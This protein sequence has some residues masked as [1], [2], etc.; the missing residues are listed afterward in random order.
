M[1]VVVVMVK[2]T[3]VV[4]A[5]CED[6]FEWLGG[7]DTQGP[8]PDLRKAGAGLPY[9]LHCPFIDWHHASTVLYQVLTCQR[10]EVTP[11]HSVTQWQNCHAHEPSF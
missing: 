11:C 5:G 6:L 10:E 7:M 4:R 3:T 8:D 2:V 9:K 1:V